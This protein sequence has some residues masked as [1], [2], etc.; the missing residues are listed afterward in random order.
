MNPKHPSA[1]SSPRLLVLGH[2]SPELQA[3]LAEPGGDFQVDF[4]AELSA[5]MTV[6]DLILL[7][8]GDDEKARQACLQRLLARAEWADTPV[9]VVV[10]RNNESSEAGWFAAGASDVVSGPLHWPDLQARLRVHLARSARIR[11]LSAAL[12]T[13]SGRAEAEARGAR[14][15]G[16]YLE[17]LLGTFPLP[18]LVVDAAGRCTHWNA[19]AERTFGI[20]AVAYVGRGDLWPV[21][22]DEPRPLLAQQIVQPDFKPELAACGEL[23]QVVPE[24]EI[25]IFE[26]FFPTLGK[27]LT[28]T[29]SPIRDQD[30]KIVGAVET[31]S[32]VSTFRQR[33]REATRLRQEAQ[34]ATET[35]SRFL[36]NMSHEIRT[37]MNAII[38]LVDLCLTTQ[39]DQ[40]QEK[41]LSK[42]R[43]ASES[44]LHIINEILDFSKIEAGKLELE[45]APFVLEQVLDQVSAVSA[46]SAEKQGIEL[47]YEIENDS[48]VLEGDLLRLGQILINLV[49][50]AIKFSAGGKVLVRVRDE[51]VEP[52]WVELRFSVSDTGIGLTEEQ[53]E[54]LFQPF[55]QADVSTTRRYG[56]TGLGLAISSLLVQHM[57]GR[58]W[59]ESAEGK[60]S[61]FHFTARFRSLGPDRRS[62]VPALAKK[63]AAYA[64]RPV[65][66][67]DDTPIACEILDRIL[68]QLGLRSIAVESGEAALD[69]VRNYRGQPLLAAFV[70]WQLPGMSGLD[71]LERIREYCQE[72]ELPVPAS[73]LVTAYSHSERLARLSSQIDSIIAK[74]VSARQAHA[75]LARALGIGVKAKVKRERRGHGVLNWDN[76][77]RLDILVA[78]DIEINREVIEELL[79]SVGIVVRFVENGAQV[80]KAVREKRPDVILMDCQMPVMDGFSATLALRADPQFA[81]LPIIALTAHASIDEKTKCRAV[82]MNG[83][84]AKPVRLEDIYKQFQTLFPP[85]IPSAE[86]SPA[87]I[88]PASSGPASVIEIPDLPG[89]DVALGIEQTG[90]NPQI[91]H[92]ILKKFRDTNIAEFEPAFLAAGHANDLTAQRHIAHSLKGVA[93]TL[94]VP[95]IA[96][97]AA[98]LEKALAAGKRD[99]ANRALAELLD[100]IQVVARGLATLE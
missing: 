81:E 5:G 12:R 16:S 61:T 100:E 13:Q 33:E 88:L 10:H 17:T 55:S 92:M 43:L 28:I 30:G 87:A 18:V 56:G 48:R 90:G 42:V 68:A 32:D 53:L 47:Y 39:L 49:S 37:P 21:F 35:K 22:Y 36:A 23:L 3:L 89:V 44:L 95:G 52:D 1:S 97:A 4:Q 24:Q 77:S 60:G 19:A 45:Q 27:Y 8:P 85:D 14:E 54:H 65:L 40:R 7:C 72:A 75:E 59:A 98:R 84:L 15:V 2:Y 51:R 74:P 57:G 46:L 31:F 9:L 79:G 83:H 64:E 62:P 11:E 29:A 34:A 63:L 41:Y 73:I 71:C 26:N 91:Y 25:Y 70:D 58:I 99:A 20:P 38:G 76:F 86:S 80:L 50:N 96:E 94:G 66:V 93:L 67:V 6:G 78:E 69:F 82:G